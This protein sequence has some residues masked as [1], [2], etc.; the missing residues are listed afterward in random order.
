V[1]A[2][3]LLKEKA[4]I[5]ATNDNSEAPLFLAAENGHKQVVKMLLDK[6]AVVNTQS[7]RFGDALQAAQLKA[8]RRW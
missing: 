6:G 8:T 5:E 2:Q 1:T 3:N 4:N 7:G